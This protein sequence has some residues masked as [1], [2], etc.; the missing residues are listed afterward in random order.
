VSGFSGN[1]HIC[2]YFI[3]P[4]RPP[5]FVVAWHCNRQGIARINLHDHQLGKVGWRR[6]ALQ[7]AYDMHGCDL[8]RIKLENYVVGRDYIYF[9]I[10]IF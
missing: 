8:L 6:T 3:R 5:G 9:I 4:V 1:V 7:R 2:R 10:F